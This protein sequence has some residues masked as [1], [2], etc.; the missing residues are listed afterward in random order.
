MLFTLIFK[1][2]GFQSLF[3]W[4]SDGRKRSGQRIIYNKNTKIR[5]KG[6][7]RKRRRKERRKGKVRENKQKKIK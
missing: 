7:K 3:L 6:R 4:F 1:V 2:F 5:I